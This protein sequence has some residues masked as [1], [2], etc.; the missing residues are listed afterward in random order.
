MDRIAD[1]RS[2]FYSLGAVYYELL[3]GQLPWQAGSFAEWLHIHITKETNMREEV[4]SS[5]WP[6]LD[7][8]LKLPRKLYGRE[9]ETESLKA[10]FAVPVSPESYL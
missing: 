5:V 2:D 7:V 3:T 10:A 4:E 8:V 6:V 1:Y 9:R